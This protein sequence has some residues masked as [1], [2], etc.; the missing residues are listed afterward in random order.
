MNYDEWISL[1]EE[2][3][4]KRFEDSVKEIDKLSCKIE[5]I[6]YSIKEGLKDL[7]DK[8]DELKLKERLKNAR[9]RNN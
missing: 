6:Q 9:Q 2:E 5:V 4:D 8:L 7:Q 3:K 1:S